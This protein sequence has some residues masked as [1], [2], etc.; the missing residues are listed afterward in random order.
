VIAVEDFT[1]VLAGTLGK[2]TIKLKRSVDH[3]WWGMA[4]G[5]N[6]WFSALRT[7]TAPEGP[8]EAEVAQALGLLDQMQAG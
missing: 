1:A 2:P 6:R 4:A 5:E 8:R 3:W 7:V